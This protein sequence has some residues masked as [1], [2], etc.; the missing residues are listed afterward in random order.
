VFGCGGNRDAGKRPRMGAIAQRLA[1]QV[2]LT[3]D[4]PRNEPPAF[5]LLQI[6][7]G[8]AGSQ[9]RVTVIEDRRAAIRHAL[10]SAGAHDVVLIA[11]KG[12]EETQEIAGV[13]RPFSD[14]AEAQAALELRA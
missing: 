14:V 10:R 4:N 3:S 13:K 7:A 6:V 5:I 1:D 2:V 12:H 8:F 9:E 11:G